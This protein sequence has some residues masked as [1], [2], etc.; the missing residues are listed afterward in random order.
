[1]IKLSPKVT[2]IVA[3]RARPQR[4]PARNALSLIKRF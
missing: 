4:T 1:M 3:I 2:D